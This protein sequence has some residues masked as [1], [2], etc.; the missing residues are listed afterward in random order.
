MNFFG[1]LWYYITLPFALVINLIYNFIPNYGVAII[2]FTLIVK[3]LLWPLTF[4]QQ[5]SM[6]DIQ[7][8]QPELR[9]IQEKYKNDKERLNQELLNFYQKHNINPASGCLPLLLQLPLIIAIYQVVTNPLTYIMNFSREIINRIADIL[10]MPSA[11]SQINLLNAIY[12]KN[13]DL[14]SHGIEGFKYINFNF[15]GLNLAQTPQAVIGQWSTNLLWIIPLLSLATAYLMSLS[16]AAT[17]SGSDEQTEQT[18]KM[19]RYML[20]LMSGYFTFVLPAGVGLYWII[21]NIVQIIQ[22]QIINRKLKPN[23]DEIIDVTP[24]KKK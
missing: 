9:K 21:S 13:I 4:K 6:R 24:K 14:A 7:K 5:K 16:T 17:T 8:V 22:Q 20:P 15:L 2:I 11:T 18:Q 10:Q 1:S 12:E 19:M 23:A 3:A